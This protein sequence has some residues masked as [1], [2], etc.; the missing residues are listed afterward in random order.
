MPKET[1]N[2]MSFESPTAV[3]E[4]TPKAPE[5]P[6]KADGPRMRKIIIHTGQNGDSDPAHWPDPNAPLGGKWLILPRNEPIEVDERA[7]LRQYKKVV[8]VDIEDPPGS[9]KVKTQWLKRFPVEAVDGLEP[10]FRD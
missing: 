5:N 8:R 2:E 10:S 6:L 4:E 7:I 1:P 9:N 3:K